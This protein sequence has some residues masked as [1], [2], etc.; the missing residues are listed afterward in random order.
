MEKYGVNE[1]QAGAIV[2]AMNTE[3]FSSIQGWVPTCPLPQQDLTRARRPPGTGKTSTICGLVQA[4]LAKRARPA[5]KIN[6]GRGPGTTEK[7]CPPKILLCAPSN[8]AIDEVA[9]RLKDGILGGGKRGLIPKVVRVGADSAINATVKDIS[10]DF[11]VDQ[12]V[13]SDPDSA[14]P[15]GSTNEIAVVRRELDLVKK[16]RQKKLEE[17]SQV[18]NNTAKTTLLE[19]EIKRLNQK[20]MALTQQV[21]RLR[22]KSKSDYRAL[23]AARRK[24][25]SEI[26][27]EADVI[28]GTLSGSG[29]E[30]LQLER[31][32][33]EMVIIDEAAQAIELSTLIPLKYKC[34]RCILVGGT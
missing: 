34:N 14:R 19:D 30:G 2:G 24:I 4:H 13:N 10:L 32:D 8:A 1:P 33:F 27:Q 26:L 31:F 28:C 15:S 22:D 17:L 23:D 21:D 12:K 29:H 20:R 5:T 18:E 7:T 25:R 11:L 3:G 6:V 16:E 9:H